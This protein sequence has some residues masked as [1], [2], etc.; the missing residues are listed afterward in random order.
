MDRE[1]KVSWVSRRNFNIKENLSKWQIGIHLEWSAPKWFALH[2]FTVQTQGG[3]V[4]DWS[5]DAAQVPVDC[6]CLR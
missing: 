2:R 3:L 1:G 6:G 4:F 5:R